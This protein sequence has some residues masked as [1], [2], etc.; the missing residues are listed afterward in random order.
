M[1]VCMYVYR[2]ALALV[3]G[4]NVDPRKKGQVEQMLR[5]KA[6]QLADK[7]VRS[8]ILAYAGVC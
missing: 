7:Q 1:Y 6:S 4:S 8:R 3:S 2:R 5:D